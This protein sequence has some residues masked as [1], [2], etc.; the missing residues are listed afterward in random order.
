MRAGFGL[1][2]LMPLMYGYAVRQ[3][4]KPFTAPGSGAI[5][6]AKSSACAA[7]YLRRMLKLDS[8]GSQQKWHSKKC[9]FRTSQSPCGC[10]S[11]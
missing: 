7:I 10:P 2:L 3:D 11:P 4:A 1:L 6:L 8:I 9:D 5:Q